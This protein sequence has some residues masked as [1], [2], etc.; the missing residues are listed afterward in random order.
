MNSTRI[1]AEAGVNHNGSMERA[2]QLIDVAA[3]AGAAAHLA[4]LH[5]ADMLRDLTRRFLAVERT[6]SADESNENILTDWRQRLPWP[7]AASPTQ[8]TA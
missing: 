4:G 6:G 2:K 3:E 1:I 7:L 5:Q 8:D